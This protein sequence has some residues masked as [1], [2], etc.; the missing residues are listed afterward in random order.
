MSRPKLDT[1]I[2]N[3]DWH[4]NVK[5]E[6]DINKNQ[7]NFYQSCPYTSKKNDCTK[8]KHRHILNVVRTLLISTSI[9]KW[10][11]DEVTLIVVY[12]INCIPSPT[13]HNKSSFKLLYGQTA[14]YSFLRV[15]GCACFVSLPI[16][17]RIKFYP[18]TRLYYFHGYGVSQKGFRC[19]DPITHRLCVSHHVEF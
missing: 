5:V 1:R 9:L 8:W 16:H 6:P 19:Y 3:R 14:D 4:A 15:F 11:W 17:E 7:L 13:T 10:F 2:C 12:T 18:S